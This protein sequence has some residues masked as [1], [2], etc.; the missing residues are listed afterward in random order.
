MT[1]GPAMTEG[2]QTIM[3]GVLTEM[4]IFR[5]VMRRMASRGGKAGTAAQLAARRKTIKKATRARMR[6]RRERA[7]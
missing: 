7:A 4:D 6:K 5:Q 2:N 1:K 3:P